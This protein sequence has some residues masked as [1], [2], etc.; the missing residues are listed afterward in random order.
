MLDYDS[1]KYYEHGEN[2]CA[3]PHVWL[4]SSRYEINQS[5]NIQEDPAGLYNS[6]SCIPYM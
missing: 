3:E 4:D 1:N 6:F 2:E 5:Y